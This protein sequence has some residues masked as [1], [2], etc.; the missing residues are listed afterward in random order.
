MMRSE[1]QKAH[2]CLDRHLISH[3]TLGLCAQ[4]GDCGNRIAHLGQ[5]RLDPLMAS[6]GNLPR[7][8]LGCVINHE[9]HLTRV[10]SMRPCEGVLTQ[11]KPSSRANT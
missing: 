4:P 5:G 2:L 11:A 10:R 3:L 8:S 7:G 1:D 6:G 9:Q